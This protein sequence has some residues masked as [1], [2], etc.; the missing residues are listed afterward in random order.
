MK[1]YSE[2]QKDKIR[3]IV[4]SCLIF[5]S[6]IFL[7]YLVLYVFSF[8]NLTEKYQ[9]GFSR[10]VDQVHYY[11]VKE[12]TSDFHSDGNNNDFPIIKIND[13]IFIGGEYDKAFKFYNKPDFKIGGFVFYIDGFEVPVTYDF[14]PGRFY[15]INFEKL[16]K[17]YIIKDIG[18]FYKKDGSDENEIWT[19]EMSDGIYSIFTK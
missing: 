17:Q 3:K 10:E 12:I 5:C 14:N 18:V 9:Q 19:D 4:F 2:I 6:F 1:K 7:V 16:Q 8:K 13:G 11:T 15:E